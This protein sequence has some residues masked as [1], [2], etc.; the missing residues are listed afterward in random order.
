MQELQARQ[1]ES[2]WTEKMIALETNINAAWEEK[3]ATSQTAWS[4][5]LST[6]S[7]PQSYYYFGI[8]AL[9]DGE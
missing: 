8:N 6:V 7:E 5:E 1:S 3:I 4:S 2:T 9:L